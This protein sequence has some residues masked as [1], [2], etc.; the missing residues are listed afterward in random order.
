M[1]VKCTD[2]QLSILPH[3]QVKAIGVYNSFLQIMR[4]HLPPG[5]SEMY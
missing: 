1:W 2:V 3:L 5:S 4:Q